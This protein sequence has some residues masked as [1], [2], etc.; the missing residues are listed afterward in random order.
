MDHGAER[1]AL[2]AM[3]HAQRSSR[4][5]LAALSLRRLAVINLKHIGDVLLTTPAIRAMRRAW[6]EAA[7]LAVVSR[8]SEDVLAGNPDV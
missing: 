3:L 8:G 4:N 5:A 7:I 6:P 1:N 2:P